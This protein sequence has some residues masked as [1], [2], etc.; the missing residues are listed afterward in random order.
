MKNLQFLFL[1]FLVL[2]CGSTKNSQS[3]EPNKIPKSKQMDTLLRGEKHVKTTNNSPLSTEPPKLIKQDTRFNNS[4]A[5]SFN[6]N[7][8]NKL[9]QAHVSEKG[10]VDYYGFKTNRFEL[11]NYIQL[12]SKN[13]PTESWNKET[14]LAYWINAYNAMTIDLILRHYPLKSIKDIKNPWDQRF[15][16]LGDKWYNLNEIEHD[17]L[18]NMNEPRI[19]FAIVCASVSCPSLQ[20]KAYTPDYIENQLTQATKAFLND[21]SK[22][23]ISENNLELS[24]IFQWFGKDFK[25]NGTL[26]DFLNT[27][28][29]INISAKAKKHF[30]DYNWDLNN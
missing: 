29:D 10:H 21:E 13:R 16:K 22:N 30:K 25:Q 14:I 7:S 6:H 18:R 26:I 1:F 8:W 12:L 11:L 15:W 9:L 3:K 19:H 24:K 23:S 17:I 27:Y 28:S 20:N 4:N 5:E 2:S